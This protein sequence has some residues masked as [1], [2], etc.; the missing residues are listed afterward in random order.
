[1]MLLPPFGII[2]HM[3]SRDESTQ[4]RPTESEYSTDFRCYS[5]GTEET[6]VLEMLKV[7]KKVKRE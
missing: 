4:A 2:L 3:D 6:A 7:E 1:M 5:P